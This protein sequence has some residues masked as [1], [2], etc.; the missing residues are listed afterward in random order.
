MEYKIILILL[1]LGIAIFSGCVEDKTVYFSSKSN[2][3]ITLYKDNTFYSK[4]SYKDYGW[5]GTYRIDGD[6]VIF[7]I[8]PFNTIIVLKKEN[9]KLINEKDGETWVRV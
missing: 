1:V 8:A 2:E 4:V 6:H 3:T 7:T 5:S 9:N